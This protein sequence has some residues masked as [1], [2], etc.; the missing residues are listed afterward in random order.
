MSY[1]IR[2]RPTALVIKD[3]SILLVQYEDENGVHYNLPGGGAE[4]GE[5]VIEGVRRELYEETMAEAVVGP[6]AIVY[7]YAPH[8]QSGE[9]DSDIHSINLIFECYL[10][11]D[12]LPR[13]P[14]HPDPDQSA[15]RWISINELD[16]IIL[17]PN[18]KDQLKKYIKD[19]RYIEIIEDH[20]LERYSLKK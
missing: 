16:E 2:V 20:Q 13:L 12:S 18:I 19:R 17:F 9:Y 15:V 6:L 11:E 10:K 1:H 3:N 7:E 4:P 8:H 14:D 5:T